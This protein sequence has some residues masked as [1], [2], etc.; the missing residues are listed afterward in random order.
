MFKILDEI[1]ASVPK[2]INLIDYV[3]VCSKDFECEI[4]EYKDIKIFYHNWV[5]EDTIYYMQNPYFDK[6]KHEV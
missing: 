2:G 5:K 1:L 4:T 6:L 3:F